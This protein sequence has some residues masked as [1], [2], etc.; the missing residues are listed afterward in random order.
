MRCAQCSRPAL[1]NIGDGEHAVP[2]CLNCWATLEEVNFRKWLQAAAMINHAQDE[3]DAIIPIGPSGGR[4]PVA[5]IARAA[6]RTRAYNNIHINNSNIGVV[7]T[8]N[9]ARI[10]AAI[11]ISTGT[12]T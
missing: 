9:L 11:T 7:N 8:G 10:D 1:Y 5:E 4:I 2:L 3:F 12:E 6:S